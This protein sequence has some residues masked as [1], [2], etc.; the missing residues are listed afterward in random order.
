MTD[1]LTLELKTPLELG[2][3]VWEKLD[4]VE[5]SVS[6]V[7]AAE[8]RVAANKNAGGTMLVLALIA[9]QTKV[10]ITSLGAM[11]WREVQIANLFFIGFSDPDVLYEGDEATIMLKKP[12]ATDGRGWPEI[13]LSEPTIGQY[14]EAEAKGGNEMLLSLIAAT[15]NVP[16]DALLGMAWSDFQRADKFFARF[17]LSPSKI[18]GSLAGSRGTEA[19]A[20]GGAALLARSFF[21]EMLAENKSDRF[22]VSRFADAMARATAEAW[23]DR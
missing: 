21:A 8:K 16:R 15:A 9:E 13:V 5:P 23:A 7:L 1:T 3:Q 20:R 18:G 10:P 19:M 12:I 4:L 11:A 14:H 22:S 17:D 2:E 6:Q